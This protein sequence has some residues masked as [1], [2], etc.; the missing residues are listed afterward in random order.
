MDALHDTEP[1]LDP[2]RLPLRERD[3][4]AL[5]FQGA[6][7]KLLEE[8]LDDVA[9]LGRRLGIV[10]LVPRNMSFALVA[11]VDEHKL[12]IDP[13]HLPLEHRVDRQYGGSDRVFTLFCSCEGEFQFLIEFVS[14]FKF[15]NEVAVDH[16]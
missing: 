16:A 10:P 12:V 1:V 2:T 9:D 4:A 8:H 3:Q 6:I 7:L 14:E 15:A 5:L 13:Q 11:H